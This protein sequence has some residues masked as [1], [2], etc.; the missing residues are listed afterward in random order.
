M[1]IRGQ[2]NS[3]AVSQPAVNECAPTDSGLSGLSAEAATRL[4][5][6]GFCVVP[7]PVPQGAFDQLARAYDRAMAEADPTDRREGRTTVRVHDFV[8]RGAEFDSLYIHRP[9]LAACRE[10]IGQ[11]FKLSSML[12]RTLL[13]ERPAQEVHVDS[14]SDAFGWTLLG[15]ILMVDEFRT[16]NGATCFLPGSHQRTVPAAGDQTVA[17]C[18]PAASMVIFNGSVWHGHGANT[19]KH[20]RRSIQGAFIR[21]DAPRGI[22]LAARMRPET[23]DR[24]SPLAKYLI[25]P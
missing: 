3:G 16:D 8:N 4:R 17:A 10:V 12:G 19:T 21:R 13:P 6:D 11:R 22:D 5:Q 18:G 1:R 7:G 9:L 15:F 23:V 2:E 25:E 20:A 24:L 14:P